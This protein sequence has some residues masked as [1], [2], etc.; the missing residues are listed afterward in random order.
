M[1]SVSR[2]PSL[3]RQHRARSQRSNHGADQT[4]GYRQA[5]L[6]WIQ[7]VE[8]HQRI[9]RARNYN[10]VEAEQQTAQG[11]GQRGF[12]QVDVWPHNLRAFEIPTH[13]TESCGR[14]AKLVRPL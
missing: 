1:R 11:A 2:P 8:A 7:T 10:S 4:D 9:D 13:P 5:L 12:D 3:C 6:L 14:R